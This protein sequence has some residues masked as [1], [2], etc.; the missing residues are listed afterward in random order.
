MERV[1]KDF[2]AA[3]KAAADAG[4]T[5]PATADV[6][7][8]RDLP[9]W[10]NVQSVNATGV[11]ITPE[12]KPGDL[13]PELRSWKEADG[14][15][16]NIGLEEPKGLGVKSTGEL[17]AAFRKKITDEEI[18]LMQSEKPED[19]KAGLESLMG[20]LLPKGFEQSLLTNKLNPQDTSSRM[21]QPMIDA[22]AS[23]PAE[24]RAELQ[25][26]VEAIGAYTDA[27]KGTVPKSK[28]GDPSTPILGM[29]WDTGQVDTLN[30]TMTNLPTNIQ[31]AMGEF[32]AAIRNVK[33][34]TE[35]TVT[36]P[37]GGSATATQDKFGPTGETGSQLAPSH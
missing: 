7:Q 14:I 36:T 25:P 12:S 22:I 24:L 30:T 13:P 28:P 29:P 1:K 3:E 37:N 19:Q 15:Y 18:T 32:I 5:K 8:W 33:I 34:A 21:F 17:A 4:I 10:Q 35:I 16:S 2:D 6:S 27:L 31:N 23:M 26:F 11:K 9:S 20:K